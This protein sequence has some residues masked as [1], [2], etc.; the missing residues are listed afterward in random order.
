MI[1]P[2]TPHTPQHFDKQAEGH[3][4]LVGGGGAA[5]SASAKAPAHNN[6]S[7]SR[8]RPRPPQPQP[9]RPGQRTKRTKRGKTTTGEGADDDGGTALLLGR[10]VALDGLEEL[11]LDEALARLQTAMAAGDKEAGSN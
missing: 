6:K 3:R 4:A 7:S 10:L 8:K 9:Q 2:I 5:A 1:A 11:P